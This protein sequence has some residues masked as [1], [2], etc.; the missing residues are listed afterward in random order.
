V[1]FEIVEIKP[2]LP[3]LYGATLAEEHVARCRR[4]WPKT[5]NDILLVLDFSCVLSVTPSYLKS[6]LLWALPSGPAEGRQLTPKGHVVDPFKLYPVVSNCTVDV[7]MDVNEFFA[8]NNLP[9]IHVTKRRA[10]RVL[11]AKLLGK[12]DEVLLRTLSAVVEK[13]AATAAD[14]AQESEETI[15]VNG[16]NNRLAD[17]HMLRLLMRKRNGKFWVYS[18]VAERITSWA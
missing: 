17:L 2:S 18:P 5:E 9:I 8:G 11:A 10:D 3:H 16:W 7:A 1:Q 6:T 14:L 12:L 13:R 15:S 4:H